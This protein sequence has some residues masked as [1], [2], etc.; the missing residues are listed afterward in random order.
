[1]Y[2]LGVIRFVRVDYGD[3]G[4]KMVKGV[5]VKIHGFNFLVD[6][7][8]I[9]YA[10]E[11]EP[12]IVFG[13]NFLV[14]TKCKGYFGLGEIRI[15]LTM[16]EAERDIDNFLVNLVEDID[17]VGCASSELVKMG[18]ATRNKNLNV[19]KLTPPAI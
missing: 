18:K 2:N 19:N 15:D 5:L 12:S 14:T 1:M 10:N 9:D 4:R 7:V 3:Y 11:G 17:E 8:V 13:R 6:F 16:L